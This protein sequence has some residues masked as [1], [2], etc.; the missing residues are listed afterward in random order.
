MSRLPSKI[1]I[2]EAELRQG[3][4]LPGLIG[5]LAGMIRRLNLLYTLIK[6]E[7]EEDES[8][9]DAGVSGW[10]DDGTNF[11]IT[12]ENGIITAIEDSTAGGHS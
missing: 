1:G 4:D 7:I 5:W 12:V 2:E 10:F 11:R 3:R 6:Q 9:I 8:K